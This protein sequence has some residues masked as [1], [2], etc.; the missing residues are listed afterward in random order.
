L[1]RGQAG[2]F[3]DRA[4]GAKEIGIAED[5]GG[6]FS[7]EFESDVFGGIEG[8]EFGEECTACRKRAGKDNGTNAGIEG[9]SAG[10][11]GAALGHLKYPWGKDGSD[12]LDVAGTN[13]W[14]KRGGL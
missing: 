9:E 5:D 2:G 3:G 11:M 7:T 4:S 6:I 8:G 14:G 10:E 12:E 1:P 13:V